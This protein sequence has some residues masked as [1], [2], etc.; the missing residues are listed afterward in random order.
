MPIQFVSQLVVMPQR[1]YVKAGRAKPR[2]KKNAPPPKI[3]P[4]P[5]VLLTVVL[6]VGFAWFLYHLSQREPVKTIAPVKTANLKKDVLPP[7]PKE[8]PYQYI[9]ELENKEIQV[10]VEDLANKGPF[11]MYCGTFRAQE[12]AEQVKAKIAFAGYVSAVRRIDGKN[13][14]F[15]RVTL[16]PYASKRQAESEKSRLERQKVAECRIAAM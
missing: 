1:D 9:K 4:W 13:G 6:V 15:F 2:A 11:E 5:L 3:F 10:K 12:T 8:E 14:V 7:K 16:G